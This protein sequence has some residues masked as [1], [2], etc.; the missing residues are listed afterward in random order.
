MKNII[1]CCGCLWHLEDYLY[2][3]K[4]VFST[5]AGIMSPCIADINNNNLQ[6]IEAVFVEFN[7]KIIPTTNL[8]EKFIAYKIKQPP[9]KDFKY[10]P[11][12]FYNKEKPSDKAIKNL[13]EHGVFVTKATHFRAL[14]EHHQ[15]YLQKNK[16]SF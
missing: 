8:M 1:L 7:E 9:H 3:I 4:G 10:S 2:K 12:V 11:R 16:P 15:K 5:K 13:E 14:N 6:G